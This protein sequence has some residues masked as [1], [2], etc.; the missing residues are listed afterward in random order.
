M[1]KMTTLLALDLLSAS[2]MFSLSNH[3]RF[4]SFE[5]LAGGLAFV[6]FIISR[7]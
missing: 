5:L 6:L 2:F 4:F 1:G 3:N 7:P